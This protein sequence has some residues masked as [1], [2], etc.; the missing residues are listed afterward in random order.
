MVYFS[1][2]ALYV[3]RCIY[4]LKW[5]NS[6]YTRMYWRRRVV[7]RAAWNVLNT[8]V[9]AWTV[10]ARWCRDVALQSVWYLFRR[11]LIYPRTRPQRGLTRSSTRHFTRSLHQ[12]STPLRLHICSTTFS[13]HHSPVNKG[14][15]TADV[16]P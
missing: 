6:D 13:N 16:L 9:F 15:F 4:W 1:Q 8:N 2:N 5:F 14:F 3:T 7:V 10:K 11:P 12:Q